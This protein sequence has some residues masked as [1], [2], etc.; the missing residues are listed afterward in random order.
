MGSNAMRG[1]PARRIGIVVA[2]PAEARTLDALDTSSVDIVVTGPGPA[3]AAEGAAAL[4][5]RG[6]GALLSWGTSGAL[7]GDLRPG[8]LVLAASV[9]DEDGCRYP[10]DADW[11]NHAQEALAGLQPTRDA[12][13]TSGQPVASVEAKHRLARVS[14]CGAVDMEAAAVARTAAAHS[15]PF[16]AIRSIVD[17]VDCE[18]PRCVLASLAPSGE[19]RVAALLGTLLRR[20]WELG[21][22]L[23]LALHFNAA[24]RTLRH[25]AR[26]MSNNPQALTVVNR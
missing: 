14:A 10:S 9:R 24:L 22:L 17:P 18:L 23:R 11:L 3:R 12:C 20:P 2:L 16:L 1:A 6:A 26:L 4:I 13:A 25:A 7:R 15:L 21:G 8:Q 5:A 19:P